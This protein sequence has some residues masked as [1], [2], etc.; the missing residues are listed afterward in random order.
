MARKLIFRL[1]RL[2][3]LVI[4]AFSITAPSGT[5]YA[6]EPATKSLKIMVYS[7]G[8]VIGMDIVAEALRRGHKVTLAVEKPEDITE[9]H[10]DLTIVRG[11]PTD[12]RDAARKIA[13]EN[14]V[15]VAT[16]SSD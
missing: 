3:V 15:I 10:K 4:V 13:P 1:A 5:L 8:G 12:L 9:S 16:S 2:C 6:K 11:D 7:D 14:V